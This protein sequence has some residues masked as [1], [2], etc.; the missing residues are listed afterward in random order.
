[1]I[2]DGINGYSG[3]ACLAVTNDQFALPATDGCHRVDGFDA[4]L[5]WF[6]NRLAFRHA[7]GDDFD[8]TRLGRGDGP[9]AI[10]RITK[11]IKHPTDNGFTNGNRKE[12]TEGSDFVTFF[13]RQVVT[14]NN[15]TNAVLFQV[16]CEAASSVWKLDHL[17]G[18]DA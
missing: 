2:Q 6:G 15:Q 16:E 8:G 7:R 4:C 10:Q 5:Q 18:H 12:L 17:V 14:Q 1:M 9:L 11:W 3:L 13:D